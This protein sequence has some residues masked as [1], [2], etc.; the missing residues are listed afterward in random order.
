MN[1]YICPVKI[2]LHNIVTFYLAILPHVA[3][4][5][6]QKLQSIILKR[7]KWK[8][9]G[10]KNKGGDTIELWIRLKTHTSMAYSSTVS[11]PHTWHSIF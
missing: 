5:K 2:I 9:E 8:K 3:E 6:Y 4:Q 7:K 1:T 10:T 11:E